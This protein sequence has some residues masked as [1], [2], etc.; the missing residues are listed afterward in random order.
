[1]SN[2][3]IYAK[4]WRTKSKEHIA[5]YNK[6][7]YQRK[8]N[9]QD[10]QTGGLLNSQD[11]ELVKDSVFISKSQAK[12]LE[13]QLYSSSSFLEPLIK[14]ESIPTISNIQSVPSVPSVS[15]PVQSISVPTKSVPSVSAPVQSIPMSTKSVSVPVQSIPMPIKS[16]PNTQKSPYHFYSKKLLKYRKLNI[17]K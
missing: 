11:N 14:N 12:E 10:Q 17:V 16:V 13:N 3:N 9:I 8:K 15:V 4:K 5:E 1:M 7:Y 6:K 2:T